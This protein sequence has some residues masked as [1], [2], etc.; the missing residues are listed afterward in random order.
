MWWQRMVTA[1]EVKSDFKQIIGMT[2]T[3]MLGKLHN[4]KQ[5]LADGIACGDVRVVDGMYY[6]K[7]QMAEQQHNSGGSAQGGL[8]F[9]MY[10]N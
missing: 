7:R 3:E 6:W 1:T 9:S 4:D 8:Q 10:G 2:K 5:A